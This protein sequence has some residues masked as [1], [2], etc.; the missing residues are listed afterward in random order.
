M[1]GQAQF[2]ICR[3]D[4]RNGKIEYGWRFRAANGEITATSGEGFT[5]TE[6]ANR[7]IHDFLRDVY[8]ASEPHP[9]IVDIDEAATP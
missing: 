5:R 4:F 7:A 3:R 2:E 9:A 6:D 1:S 8:G